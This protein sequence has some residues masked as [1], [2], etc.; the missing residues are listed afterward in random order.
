MQLSNP[1][2]VFNLDDFLPSDGEDGFEMLYAEGVLSLD[3][4]YETDDSAPRNARRRIRFLQA[5]YFFKT[6]FPG[7]SFFSCSDHRDTPLLNSVV[8]YGHSD[9]LEMEQKTSGSTGYKHYRLFLHS[10]GIAIHVIAQSC[11]ISSEELID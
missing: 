9:M 8:E 7:Y 5:K 4:F 3:I 6:P 11:E 2:E 1:I 10:T